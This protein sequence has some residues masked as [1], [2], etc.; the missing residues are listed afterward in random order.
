MPS[1]IADAPRRKAKKSFTL[2]LESVAFL[3]AMRKQRR[4]G[5]TSAILDEILESVRREH[6]RA[7]VDLAVADYYGSLSTGEA[8]EQAQWA[9]FALSEFPGSERG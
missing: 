1:R 8:L 5:S 3:E 7:S 2:S 4:V 6:E 9:D